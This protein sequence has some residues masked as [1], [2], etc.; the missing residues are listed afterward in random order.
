[1]GLFSL[2][3]SVN[4]KYTVKNI[5]N[6]IHD[7]KKEGQKSINGKIV[8]RIAMTKVERHVRTKIAGTQ[9]PLSSNH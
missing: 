5:I 8:M 7:A 6:S 9:E 2:G 3:P 1:M 4:T